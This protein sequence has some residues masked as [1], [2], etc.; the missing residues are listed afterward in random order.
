M[1]SEARINRLPAEE[2]TA[3]LIYLL[4]RRDLQRRF[5]L[6]TNTDTSPCQN[7]SLYIKLTRKLIGPLTWTDC[8]TYNTVAAQRL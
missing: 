5:G 1:E 4:E 6:R 3:S 2:S 7:I 8:Q